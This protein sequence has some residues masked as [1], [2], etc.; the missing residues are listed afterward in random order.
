[1]TEQQKKIRIMVTAAFFVALDILTARY[2]G[3]EL[4]SPIG[5]IKFDFQLVVAALCGYVLGPWQ[6]GLTLVC[7]DLLGAALNSGS[8]GIFLGFTLSAAVRGVLFGFLLHEKKLSLPRM[9]GSIALVFLITDW[10]LNTLW[11]SIMLG[12][13][14]FPY[15]LARFF[16]KMVLLIA[17]LGVSLCL[18]KLFTLL[19]KRRI[20]G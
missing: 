8:L 12:T 18:G 14:Y 10:G 2:L 3:F 1:M 7:S 16:P 19:Q 15:L 11:L 20:A 6:A 5:P 13:P 17:D 4:P 9:A